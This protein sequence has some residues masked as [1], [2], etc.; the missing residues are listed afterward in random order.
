MHGAM[1]EYVNDSGR[2]GEEGIFHIEKQGQKRGIQTIFPFK[3]NNIKSPYNKNKQTQKPQRH[4][5]HVQ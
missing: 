3:N 4:E 2:A 1:Y 5:Q